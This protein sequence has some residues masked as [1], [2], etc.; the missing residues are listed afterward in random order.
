MNKT[1]WKPESEIAFTLEGYSR[2]GILSCGTCAN[3]SF[4]GGRSGMETLRTV[5]DSHDI[6]VGLSR[7]ILACCP[8]EIMRQATVDADRPLR[9]GLHETACTP[10]QAR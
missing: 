10:L 1:I 9:P 3:L 6:G 4:T 5:L 8:E 7:V 2:V